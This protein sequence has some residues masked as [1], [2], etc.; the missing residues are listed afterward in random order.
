MTVTIGLLV[1]CNEKSAPPA[2]AASGSG[3]STPAATPP[4]TA[5]SGRLPGEIVDYQELPTNEIAA[6]EVVP[7]KPNY[8]MQD[9]GEYG[10]QP[11]LSENE[12]KAGRATSALIMVRYLGEHD[13]TQSVKFVDGRISSIISCTSP[14]KFV[15]ERDFYAGRLVKTETVPVTDNS[16][17][18]AVMHDAFAGNLR[19]YRQKG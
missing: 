8:A 5:Q 17:I 1:G 2:Q 11:A 12:I 18:R 19:V 4:S 14:C 7:D 6:S 16:L 15:K 10:Y 13:G 3:T 9:D